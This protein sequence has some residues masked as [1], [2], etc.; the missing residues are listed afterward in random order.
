VRGT[1]DGTGLTAEH[2]AV[3]AGQIDQRAVERIALR[4]GGPRALPEL[5][6]AH[7]A[8]HATGDARGALA[9]AAGAERG[10]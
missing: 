2:V 1:V 10:A 5:Q 6:L 8:G 9:G 3:E 4:A 7:R